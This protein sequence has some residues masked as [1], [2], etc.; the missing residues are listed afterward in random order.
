MDT[1]VA[2]AFLFFSVSMSL[3]PGAGNI[4]LLGISNRYGF[5]A[6]LP[7]VAGTAFGVLVVFGGTSAGLL[8]VLTAFPGVYTIIKYL[9]MAY[10]LYLAWGISRF[11][12]EEETPQPMPAHG[13]GFIAGTLVQVL[14][15]KAWIAAITAF[16]Q[17]TDVSGSYLIQVMTIITVFVLS[18]ILCTL[19]WA[20]FG[21]ALKRLL[22][23]PQQML[24]V[25]RCLG[26][27]LALTVVFMLIQPD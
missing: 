12:V 24:L 21:A 8:S 11:R 14:N 1:Q 13:A 3:T 4:T 10:L 17:F 6:A 23:S 26:G 25:N 9:G 20:Y 15:P 2:I 5:S 19:V 7:F 16:S 27:T 22:R 18:V